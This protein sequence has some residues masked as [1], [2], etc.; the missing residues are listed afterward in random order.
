MIRAVR[1]NSHITFGCLS[2]WFAYDSSAFMRGECQNIPTPVSSFTVSEFPYCRHVKRGLQKFFFKILQYK[3]AALAA[4]TVPGQKYS[5]LR[6]HTPS[7]HK[8]LR[9][10]DCSI[11]SRGMGLLICII[12]CA[13]SEWTMSLQL[14]RTAFLTT[15]LERA[16]I[17]FPCFRTRLVSLRRTVD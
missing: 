16:Y 13:N 9:N 8:L 7:L 6:F 4:V 3:L 2:L 5:H 15:N 11:I 10:L 12:E 17:S 1:H 14:V